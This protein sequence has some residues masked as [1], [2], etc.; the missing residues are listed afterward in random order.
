MNINIRKIL[1]FI[2]WRIVI[3]RYV[4][5]IRDLR[6]SKLF[7]PSPPRMAQ[8][9]QINST[10]FAPGPSIP[11]HEL[12]KI[13]S[14]YNPRSLSVVPKAS[15][16]PFI[17]LFNDDDIHEDNPVFRFAFS[18]EVL[19]AAADYFGGRV[20]LDSIQVLHSWPTEGSL[21][22]SQFWH[23]DYGDTKSF[24]CV[25]YI[26]DVHTA[27]HGPFVFVN[28]ATT[29]HVGRGW[30][31]RRIPDETFARLIGDGQVEYF[32]GDAGSSV[33][34]DPSIC[35]HYGSRCKVPRLAIFATFSTLFPFAQP[36]PLVTK[37]AHRIYEKAKLVRPDLS[38]AF[39]HMLLQLDG[40]NTSA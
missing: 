5:M 20:L 31:I 33:L 12:E 19:D 28:K 13:A 36:I 15:G 1:S 17:N 21:R 18:R 7:R 16:H 27:E 37:N 24:H 38:T 25:A 11:Q 2:R 30:T 34:I 3:V 40:R 4:T 14:I 9:Q 23:L 32:Y 10:G 39:L 6:F 8:T 26:K 29:K 22:E 35:Y